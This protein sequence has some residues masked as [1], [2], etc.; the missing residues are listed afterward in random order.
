MN[1]TLSEKKVHFRLG[2]HFC[3]SALLCLVVSFLGFA[4]SAET[5]VWQDKLD[6]A[7]PDDRWFAENGVWQIGS[8]TNGPA[9][10]ILG[11]RAYSGCKTATTALTGDYPAHAD[12][13]LV[14][15]ASFVVP[16]AT[17]YPRLRFWHWY[18]FAGGCSCGFG[19]T[20]EGSYGYVE[21]KP[22]GGNWE[23]V[24]PQYYLS[25][26]GVWTRPSISLTAYAGQTVQV[27]FHFHSAGCVTLGWYL[28]DVALL[29]DEPVINNP[30]GFELGL[31]D[32]YAERGT[33]EV[34]TPTS[35]PGGA[36][37]GTN[38]AA[39]VLGDNY[40]SYVD[41]RLISPGFIVPAS[42]NYPRLT[43]WQWHSFAGG[44]SCGF[45]CTDEGTYGIVEIKAGTNQWKPIS[46]TYRG[47]SC[48]GWWK[49]SIDLQPYA[50]QA[51]QLAFYF[52][53]ASCNGAGW[54]VDDVT[55]EV[56][57][58]DLYNP[59][60]FESGIGGWS[61]DFGTWQ[62][63]MPTS[64]PGAAHG[65][66]N[67]AATIL[68]TNYCSFSDSRF[69]S[70]AI[71]VPPAS[72]NP[73]LR[74][75]HW[76]SFAGSCSCGFG[77]SDGGSYG[78][79]EVKAGNNNW[80]TISPI[81]SGNSGNW[82]QPFID[83]S[84]FGGQTVQLG[85]H[86][87]SAGCIAHGWYVDDIRL[88]HDFALLLLDSP[89]VRTQ[90]TACFSLGIA[91]SSPAATIGFTL[92]STVD[93]LTN[94]VLNTEGCWTG[95]LTPQPASQ[96]SVNLQNVCTNVPMGIKR[97]NSICFTA[98]GSESAFV[99][100]TVGNLSVSNLD[101]FLPGTIGVGNRAVIIA[102]KPLLEASVGAGRVLTTYGKANAS[103]QID[104]ATNLFPTPNWA[105]GWTNLVPP[106]LSYTSPV[107]GSVSN[108]PLLF[109]RA[110]ER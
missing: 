50:G 56:G 2:A 86:F 16:P 6:D 73:G 93:R 41:S 74:F 10:N 64:G 25:S 76:Y 26:S 14:R 60:G 45:G 35:G 55:I 57:L 48:E 12:S 85:F 106:S 104:Y 72:A 62:V 91:Q 3:R 63:G 19:C 40:A 69:I 43:F 100:I 108:E 98:L 109:L 7:N 20:D 27:A 9:T 29:T 59:E 39:T 32:W 15:I 65:G 1:M 79:L 17:N 49:P 77:C 51:V 90:T 47:A 4:A 107:Q 54:Y 71:M 11:C 103:Y 75:W 66:S 82:T 78:Y 70:P 80:A 97:V 95:S 34:G 67:C 18:S 42:N 31:G 53:S 22:S 8:P 61:T 33:W 96:W 105:P 101:T 81:Y 28:D 46:V 37:G 99:P 13:R 92:K 52:H 102:D 38:C 84:A 5:V 36:H 89:A 23:T 110:M 30:E 58:Q 68:A 87:H 44:C 24:S 21:I 94:L 83:L 88:T